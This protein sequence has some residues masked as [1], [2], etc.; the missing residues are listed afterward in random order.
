MQSIGN[1]ANAAETDSLVESMKEAQNVMWQVVT[2][3]DNLR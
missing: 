2:T 1:S 3:L